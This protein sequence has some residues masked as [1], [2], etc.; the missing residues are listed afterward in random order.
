[1]VTVLPWDAPRDTHHLLHHL[2]QQ[3]A[4]AA[5]APGRISPDSLRNNTSGDAAA[6]AQQ[7]ADVSG[8]LMVQLQFHVGMW[9]AHSQLLLLPL[10][11][12]FSLTS[13]AVAL[14]Q[15]QIALELLLTTAPS[16][17]VLVKDVSLVPQLGLQ[18]VEGPH[19]A[20]HFPLPLLL[21]P[22][23]SAAL[24][25]VLTRAMGEFSVP[26]PQST[27]V[28]AT[29][30]ATPGTCHLL[31][32]SVASTFVCFCLIY[33]CIAPH[34][35]I[36][37]SLRTCPH[38]TEPHP[39]FPV[40]CCAVLCCAVLCCAVLC[41]AVL[42]CAVLCCAVLCCITTDVSLSATFQGD[43]GC[44]MVQLLY[45]VHR[46]TS[47]AVV[48]GAGAGA[49]PLPPPPSTL[50]PPGAIA[51]AGGS[52]SGLASS[53]SFSA[54]ASGLGPEQLSS[55]QGGLSGSSSSRAL[56]Q[57]QA[58]AAGG[59]ELTSCDEASNLG[60]APVLTHSYCFTLNFPHCAEFEEPQLSLL[61]LGPVTATV[62]QPTC[63]TWQVR[64]LQQPVPLG[65]TQVDP[66]LT[67]TGSVPQQGSAGLPALHSSGSGGGLFSRHSMAVAD[68]GE[69]TIAEDTLYYELVY[70][71]PLDPAAAKRSPTPAAGGAAAAGGGGRAS[72][73]PQQLAAVAADGSP[74]LPAAAA[75]DPRWRATGSIRLGRAP[76]S[77]AV[78]EAVVVP[79]ASGQVMPPRLV[80]HGPAG[81]HGG[82][83]LAGDSRQGR[84]EV[85]TI[86]VTP[87]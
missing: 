43:L 68:A 49:A 29:L 24:T 22:G 76:D 9:R 36:H 25:F 59:Q 7:D 75:W 74:V 84:Q 54:R 83:V 44:S 14:P 78:V 20:A 26:G 4:A 45:S 80:V 73:A 81:R 67:A 30:R 50:P 11:Q 23:A 66:G 46:A 16:C 51:A 18:L 85:D 6:A 34:G 87:A 53:S 60:T 47:E 41:C 56:D 2:Q 15:G 37:P 3:Q 77:L 8:E 55:L 39:C 69:D 63:L 70:E 86:T 65:S 17:S 33:G 21:Q 71:D 28:V 35:H 1:V 10:T 32:Q 13:R 19:G 48:L 5:G 31:T 52:L 27:C 61:L 62:G 79:R 12:P 64:R 38:S 42:F 57:Q 82:R 72:P 40:L 58:A